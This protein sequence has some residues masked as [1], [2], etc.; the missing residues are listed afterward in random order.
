MLD[1]EAILRKRPVE[2]RAVDVPEW[3]GEVYVRVLSGRERDAFETAAAKNQVN[4]RARLACMCLCDDKGERL[5]QDNEFPKL[6]D[7]DGRGLD[8]VFDAACELNRLRA[9][10]IEAEEKN[11]EE[12]SE[13]AGTS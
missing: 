12:P 9:S 11:S 13:N 10:D 5:F 8:R 7:L 1:R 4:L 2:T 3:G 6:G